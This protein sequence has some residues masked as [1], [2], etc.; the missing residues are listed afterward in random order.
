MGKSVSVWVTVKR[1]SKVKDDALYFVMKRGMFYRPRAEGYADSMG[2]AGTYLGK[3]A[4]KYLTD[5]GVTLHPVKPLLRVIHKEI[6][7]RLRQA[8]NLATIFEKF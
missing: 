3:E 6:G 5:E 2:D 8:A 1:A 7:M 4:K